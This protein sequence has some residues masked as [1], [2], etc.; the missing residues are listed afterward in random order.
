MGHTLRKFLGRPAA[1]RRLLLHALALYL[2]IVA[3][4]RV[5]P[6]GRLTRWLDAVYGRAPAA[7]APATSH[8]ASAR[9][10]NPR[11]T[12][13]LAEAPEARRRQ[14]PAIDALD[15][16]RVAWAVRTVA[17]QTPAGDAC[18]AEALTA[19]CLLR[20]GG[21]AAALRIGVTRADAA[22]ASIAAH[23][24]LEH[25]GRIIVGGAA[26]PAYDILQPTGAMRGER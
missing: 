15:A 18:L 11:A 8:P 7:R 21:H 6:H 3:L 26:A 17:A 24:W 14:P 23:A 22:P 19:L 9:R 20:R 10:Q 1:D 2:A 12:A 16:G 5:V 13:R 4:L 25:A